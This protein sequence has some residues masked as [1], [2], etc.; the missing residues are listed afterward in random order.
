M[1]KKSLFSL[2]AT[3]LAGMANAT[4]TQLALNNGQ[5]DIPAILSLPQNRNL[6]TFPAVILLHGTGTQKN[7]VGDLYKSLSEYLIEKGIASI[8][9]DFAGNGDSKESDMTYTLSTAVKDAQTAFTYLQSHQSIDKTKIGVV[10]FSQGALIAQLLVIKEPSIKS[11]VAWSPAIGDDENP[12]KVF[13][14]TYYH[15]AKKNGHALIQYDWRAPFKVNLAWFEELKKQQ[16]L[17]QMEKFK[18]SLL[19]ISG[20]DDAV[21]PWQNANILVDASGSIDATAIVMKGA[22][23]IFNVFDPKA[24]Q[25]MDLLEITSTWL[26]SRL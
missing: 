8:R 7:E 11:M 16:S 6:Q 26:K 17:T 9:I 19:A 4:E 10:G 3:C 22:D 13:F 23:H 1:F 21:L 15:E 12:M 5:Y 2:M 24:H 14:D 18:G 20:S 25:S